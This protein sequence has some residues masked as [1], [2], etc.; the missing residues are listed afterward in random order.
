MKGIICGIALTALASFGAMADDY[1]INVRGIERIVSI[2]DNF[3]YPEMPEALFQSN[4]VDDGY[5]AQNESEGEYF[6]RVFEEGILRDSG[7][8]LESRTLGNVNWIFEKEPDGM[9]YTVKGYN[10]ENPNIKY[11]TFEE[12]IIDP[13]LIGLG[14]SVIGALLLVGSVYIKK[15]FFD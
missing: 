12:V 14:I 13:L 2:D 4:V 6:T 3:G 10:L 7:P 1:L 15:R 5:P 9:T 8:R 11:G